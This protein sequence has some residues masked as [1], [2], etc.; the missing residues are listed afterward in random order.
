MQRVK[1]FFAQIP[2]HDVRSSQPLKCCRCSVSGVIYWTLKGYKR[3]RSFNDKI[4]YLRIGLSHNSIHNKA[5]CEKICP[6]SVS[7]CDLCW[8]RIT[9]FSFQD[10][11][12]NKITDL[13]ILYSSIYRM[14]RSDKIFIQISFFIR[15]EIVY[16]YYFMCVHYILKIFVCAESFLVMILRTWMLIFITHIC[17]VN[18]CSNNLSLCILNLSE[19]KVGRRLKV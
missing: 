3:L 10:L 14:T 12:A 17:L 13:F 1:Y 19:H 15:L 8:F 6:C 9:Q 7:V 11:P 16:A 2:R 18:L 4:Q 5:V